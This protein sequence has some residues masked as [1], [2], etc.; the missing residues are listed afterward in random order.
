MLSR[1]RTLFVAH[2]ESSFNAALS[3][4]SFFPRCIQVVKLSRVCFTSMP[5]MTESIE[6]SSKIWSSVKYIFLV[7]LAIK[8]KENSLSC[9]VCIRVCV[10]VRVSECVMCLH[11]CPVRFSE[12]G[13]GGI[14]R[15]DACEHGSVGPSA[16]PL[17]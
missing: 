15:I 14:V 10:S 4:D 8:L 16:G 5:R 13:L 9:F 17:F 1:E 2:V 3:S 12:L 11:I 7:F 6:T